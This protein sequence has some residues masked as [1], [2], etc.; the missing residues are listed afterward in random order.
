MF[1]CFEPPKQW[2]QQII[3]IFSLRDEEKM[4][5]NGSNKSPDEKN[6]DWNFVTMTFFPSEFSICHTFSFKL[7]EYFTEFV[8]LWEKSILVSIIINYTL[9]Y[10]ADH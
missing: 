6:D 2:Q 10:T 3:R 1:I 8:R 7:N 4:I 9:H 5:S